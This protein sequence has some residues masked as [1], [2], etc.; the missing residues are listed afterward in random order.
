MIIKGNNISLEKLWKFKRAAKEM[1]MS[2][3]GELE[4]NCPVEGHPFD[5]RRYQVATLVIVCEKGIYHSDNQACHAGLAIYKPRRES[6]D[7]CF[8]KPIGIITAIQSEYGNWKDKVDRG[9][10][11]DYLHWLMNE[12]PYKDA[13][14]T[15]DPRIA[16]EY[17]AMLT[18]EVT[19]EY[20]AGACVSLRAI[21]ENTPI[22][23]VWHKL[24]ANGM[25]KNLAYYVAHTAYIDV[26]EGGIQF[27]KNWDGHCALNA[28]SS[29]AKVLNFVTYGDCKAHKNQGNLYSDTL[30][31]KYINRYWE[32]HP[33]D[34]SKGGYN[35]QFKSLL[36]ESIRV[37]KLVNSG[38]ATNKNPFARAVDAGVPPFVGEKDIPKFVEAMTE[39]VFKGHKEK[40]S[41]AA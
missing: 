30:Y 5:R 19:G 27:N 4:G 39:L 21:W 37:A 9:I 33:E 10:V 23:L 29:C 13:F 12:S 15:R 8:G 41:E 34:L 18:A 25:D 11:H 40:V 7:D 26:R 20:L 28:N 1:E 14:I 36:S 3:R 32:H 38:V 16:I 2:L 22:M 6:F 35:G 31:Y 17:G 24:V